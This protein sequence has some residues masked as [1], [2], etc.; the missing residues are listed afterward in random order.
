[1]MAAQGLQPHDAQPRKWNADKIWY[2][3][4]SA[5]TNPD[6]GRQCIG[7]GVYCKDHDTCQEMRVNCAGIDATN[8]ITRAEL[9]GLLCC[10]HEMGTEKDEI[11]AT[12]S[13]ACMYLIAR[14]I[15]SPARNIESKHRVLINEIARLVLHRAK[16]GRDTTII[17]VKSHSGIKGNDMA[18]KLANEAALG[19]T[20]HATS[21]GNQAFEGIN[22]PQII[23]DEK[24]SPTAAD[25]D[26][27]ME[28]NTEG[29]MLNNLH[30]A[31][32][33]QAKKTYQTG[34]AN[35]TQYVRLWQDVL[36]DMHGPL[37]NAF[38]H[39]PEVSGAAKT[40]LL[41]ARYGQLWTKRMAYKYRMPYMPGMRVAMDMKCPLCGRDDSISHLL[42]GC[43]H[44]E[45]DGAYIERHNEAAR[46]VLGEVLKGHHGNSMRLVCADI[47]RVEKVQHLGIDAGKMRVPNS[48]ISD[49]TFEQIGVSPELR[50]KIRPDAL[51]IE[52]SNMPVG[53]KRLRNA[54]M[55][56]NI[57]TLT[58][59]R[60]GPRRCK[61]YVIEVGY[62]QETRYHDKLQDKSD[63]HQTLI[64]LLEAQG[65]EPITVPIIMGNTGGIFHSY[66]EAMNT[67]GISNARQK[68][69]TRRLHVHSITSM[70]GLIKLR[71]V[72]E[73]N[74]LQ[75][76]LPKHKKPPDR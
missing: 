39:I 2:T 8:T 54:R 57:P 69:L 25:G 68:S 23:A 15:R 28:G 26:E 76:Q 27:D 49:R 48:I 33:E 35:H 66:L 40:Q 5:R 60:E 59:G 7:A 75:P 22:W 41:R 38:W 52:N 31:L 70:H 47:G 4:G 12:D 64:N 67:L 11:I 43:A 37:S 21:I 58:R 30:T 53:L 18:D 19:N 1:M 17:K 32:K 62:T 74:A 73:S 71:R 24:T 36:P 6:S 10:L 51:I 42:G 16:E 56:E 46:L 44:Q 29:Y 9:C 20:T 50:D 34:L 3:D 55:A 13:Q 63:Q 65:Y 61:A 45:F 72:L 14:D